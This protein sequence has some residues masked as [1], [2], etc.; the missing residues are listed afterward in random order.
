MSNTRELTGS[1]EFLDN[2]KRHRGWKEKIAGS[3]GELS[4]HLTE[5]KVFSLRRVEGSQPTHGGE[6]AGASGRKS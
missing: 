5:K 3:S 2:K 4:K 1:E 6:R